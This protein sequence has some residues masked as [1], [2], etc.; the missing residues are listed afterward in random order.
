MTA[1]ILVPLPLNKAFVLILGY[2]VPSENVGT[3]MIRKV[4]PTAWNR[5]DWSIKDIEIEYNRR[6][7]PR[8][9]KK[10]KKLVHCV[11]KRRGY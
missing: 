5:Q 6:E 1:E 2:G 11:N 9:N 10:S 8:I 4:N 7:N 3:K